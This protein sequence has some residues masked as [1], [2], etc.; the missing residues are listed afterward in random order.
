MKNKGE[1]I[2]N[3][4]GDFHTHPDVRD[5][6]KR[7]KEDGFKVPPF[8]K[9]RDAFLEAG[10]ELGPSHG[11]VLAV[12]ARKHTEGDYDTTCV[13]SGINSMIKS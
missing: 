6:M 10:E 2:N 11:D 13:G 12:L 1:N 5:I 7:M 3:I 8:N 4:Q 9:A